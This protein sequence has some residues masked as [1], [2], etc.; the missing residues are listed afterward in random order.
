MPHTL[1][2]GTSC[3]LL[4]KHIS[5]S[6]GAL[7]V[8]AGGRKTCRET[9]HEGLLGCSSKSSLEGDHE[10]KAPAGNGRAE[11]QCRQGLYP[12]VLPARHQG[13]AVSYCRPQSPC[14]VWWLLPTC[15]PLAWR[16]NLRCTHHPYCFPH[17]HTFVNISFIKLPSITKTECAICFLQDTERHAGYCLISCKK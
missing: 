6:R 8:Q 2:I 7:P 9:G 11:A 17:P 1:S 5:Q 12:A 14:L 15:I 3:W 13:F 10:G 4:I 16:G